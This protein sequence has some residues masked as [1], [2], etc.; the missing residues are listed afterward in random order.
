MI[1]YNPILQVIDYKNLQISVLR[2]DLIHPEISGNKWFKLKYNLQQAMIEDKKCIVTFGG[3][4]SNHIAA[5]AF[6]CKE[7]GIKSIGIIRGENY[8]NLNNTLAQAK[9]NGM[10]IKFLTRQ[11]YKLKNTEAYQ[12]DFQ[13]QF[14]D[15]YIIPEGGDNEL[16]VKGC[17][18]I[19]TQQTRS[20]NN[21]YCACGTGTTYKGIS[22]SL[23]EHQK[24]Y[25]INVLKFETQTE[26]KQSN[27][28]NQYHFGGYAKHT[29]ELLNFKN[30]FE[31]TFGIALDYVYTAK[32]FFAVFDLIDK[33]ELLKS[34]QILIIHTGGLQGNIGYEKR[35]NLNPNRQVID[36]EG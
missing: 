10:E 23:A 7:A 16:G 32:L 12:E 31:K 36:P 15:A 5:T 8:S 34:D 2:L 21:I 26:Q 3:A 19:L 25:G 9:K 35:Y 13:K 18:E 29:A 22:N 1:N 11:D 33:K 17:E 24:L 27:I 30:W 4:Y 14:P 6:A 28:L 20:F